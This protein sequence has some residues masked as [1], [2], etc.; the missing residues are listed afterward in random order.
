MCVVVYTYTTHHS[1]VDT[2]Q[3]LW[4][5]KHWTVEDKAA[6]HTDAV[7]QKF[8]QEKFMLNTYVLH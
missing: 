5:H 7:Q 8:P 1:L 6:G 3:E 2:T 4:S